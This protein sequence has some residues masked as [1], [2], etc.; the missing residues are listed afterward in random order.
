VRPILFVAIAIL[1]AG[2]P[3]GPRADTAAADSSRNAAP[4]SPSFRDR[5]VPSLAPSSHFLRDGY[6]AA[7]TGYLTLSLN[8]NDMQWYTPPTRLDAALQGAGT[9]GTLGMFVGAVGN[10]LGLFDEETTWILTGSLAAAGA[11]YGGAAYEP[12]PRL[13]I[14]AWGKR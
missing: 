14:E 8:P 12:R 3:I 7:G 1:L 5:L 11:L 10:T 6:S 9:A 2:S 4:A 13:R